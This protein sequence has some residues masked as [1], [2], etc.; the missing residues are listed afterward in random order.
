MSATQRHL[1]E[2]YFA[3][4]R[5]SDHPRILATLTD[6][7]EWVIHGHRT[8]RGKAEFDGEIENPR[9]HR[10]PRTRRPAGPR[11]RPGRRHHRRG[12]RRQR[13]PRAV[14]LRLQRPVHLP[15]RADRPRRLLRGPAAVIALPGLTGSPRHSATQPSAGVVSIRPGQHRRTADLA[16]TWQ[17]RVGLRATWWT[18]VA[19]CRA[20]KYPSGPMSTEQGFRAGAVRSGIPGRLSLAC[21]RRWTTGR[22]AWP[23]TRSTF[24]NRR[25][26]SSTARGSSSAG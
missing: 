2:D 25:S 12:P 11:G 19:L 7:V 6:D 18:A 15:R 4:F 24:S 16:W 1:V 17:R 23:R 10:Q 13:R 3:G 14:P 8:T 9:L 20:R 21:R 22:P 26:A 5:A